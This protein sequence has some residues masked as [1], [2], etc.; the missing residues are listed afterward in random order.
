MTLPVFPSSSLPC[1]IWPVNAGPT[2]T[3]LLY[4]VVAPNTLQP[5]DT[6]VISGESLSQLTLTI[7]N[8]GVAV[9]RTAINLTV[10]AF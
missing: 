1:L 2:G 3:V 10:G 6:P 7:M 8:G 5:G 9:S 4:P